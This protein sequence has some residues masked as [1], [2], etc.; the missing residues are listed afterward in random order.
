MK[1]MFRFFLAL[2]ICL[3][4]MIGASTHPALAAGIITYSVDRSTVGAGE[5]FT[6]FVNVDATPGLFGAQLSLNYDNTRLEVIEVR[7]GSGFPVGSTYANSSY[8]DGGTANEYIQF[9]AVVTNPALTVL[10]GSLVEV[11]FE[12]K[13]TASQVTTQISNGSILP[14]ILADKDGQEIPS[15]P[16]NPITI[17][18]TPTAQVT[19]TVTLQAPTTSRVITVNIANAS[20]QASAN[21]LSGQLFTLNVPPASDYTLTASAACHLSARKTNVTSPSSGHSTTL[22]AGDINTDSTINI[23]DLAMIAIKFGLSGVTGCENLNGDAA[24]LVNILDLTLAAGNFG[25]SGP[26]T[27]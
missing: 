24:G 12:A 21:I 15:T 23:L 13:P 14:L 9:Y 10:A 4:A 2:A 11:V 27:W 5:R 6:L 20:Y 16:P 1:A 22:K 18:I 19:G 7:T 25:K 17:T 3:V 8:S 26:T